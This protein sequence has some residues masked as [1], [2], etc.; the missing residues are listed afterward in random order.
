MEFSLSIALTILTVIMQT[1]YAS[2]NEWQ[3]DGINDTSL[4]SPHQRTSIG[5]G[6][7]CCLRHR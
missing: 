6:F 7:G 3:S 1:V 2:V 4:L 5:N